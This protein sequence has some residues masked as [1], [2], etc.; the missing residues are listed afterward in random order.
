VV[1]GHHKRSQILVGSEP[2]RGKVKFCNDDLGYHFNSGLEYVYLSKTD[3][4][5]QSCLVS[6]RFGLERGFPLKSRTLCKNSTFSA[7]LGV[8]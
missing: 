4:Q 7:R 6:L 5:Q 3:K 1:A 2:R 8:L